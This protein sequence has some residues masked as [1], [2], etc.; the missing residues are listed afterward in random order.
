MYTKTDVYDSSRL[1]SYSTIYSGSYSTHLINVWETSWILGVSEATVWNWSNRGVVRAGRL[2]G[3][4]S[5]RFDWD[6]MER[7]RQEM[8]S[9]LEPMEERSVIEH[10]RRVGSSGGTISARRADVTVAREVR[11][12]R[13]WIDRRQTPGRFGGSYAKEAAPFGHRQLAWRVRYEARLLHRDVP[14]HCSPA[15]RSLPWG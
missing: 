10:H 5:R 8:M 15:S 4:G 14:N 11:S 13:R 7:V 1:E 6:Q 2:P 3:S 9:E 12:D